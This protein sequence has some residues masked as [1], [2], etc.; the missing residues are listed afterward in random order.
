MP[1]SHLILCHP[2]LLLSSVLPSIRVFSKESVLRIRWPKYGSFSFSIILPIFILPMSIQDWFPLWLTGLV[3]L[4]SKGVSRVFSNTT[5]QKHQSSMVLLYGPTLTSIHDY[6]KN[7]SFDYM[8]LC[9]Q[10]LK[11][12][13]TLPNYSQIIIRNQSVVAASA[14]ATQKHAEGQDHCESNHSWSGHRQAAA[15]GQR[16]QVSVNPTSRTSLG[17]GE[18]LHSG[19][20]LT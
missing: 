11:S 10:N 8:N 5:V 15:S 19:L 18:V 16:P 17:L 6:W 13:F 12:K 2:F 20:S 9:W 3:S 14:Y 4:L 7:Y 1:S